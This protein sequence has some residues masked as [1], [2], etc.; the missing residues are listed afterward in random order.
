MKHLLSSEDMEA[1]SAG[2]GCCSRVDPG[3]NSTVSVVLSYGALE[4]ENSSRGQIHHAET[5]QAG[6]EDQAIVGLE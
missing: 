6:R 2:G 3:S 5:A 1:G 4:V